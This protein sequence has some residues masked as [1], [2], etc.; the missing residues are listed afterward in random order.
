MRVQRLRATAI[1]Y[2]K[3]RTNKQ[4]KLASSTCPICLEAGINIPKLALR[5]SVVFQ[6]G[7]PFS[8]ESNFVEPMPRGEKR[9]EQSERRENRSPRRLRHHGFDDAEDV[10][11]QDRVT[12]MLPADAAPA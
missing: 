2:L 10:R 6:R 9:D 7:G 5:R 11:G 12:S 4:P 3:I 1:S 8:A